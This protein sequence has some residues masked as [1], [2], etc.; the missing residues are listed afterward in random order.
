LV[1]FIFSQVLGVNQKYLIHSSRPCNTISGSWKVITSKESNLSDQTSKE[2]AL[3]DQT[4]N[5]N[6]A[7]RVGT[8]ATEVTNEE[9][10]KVGLPP[11][12]VVES[13]EELA[14]V[15]EW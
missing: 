3:S 7:R 14:Q 4:S 11:Q 13:E 1:K 9:S 5:S 12:V 15:L 8:L 2:S 6:F 10:P